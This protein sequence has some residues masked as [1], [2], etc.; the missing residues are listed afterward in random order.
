MKTSKLTG[1]ILI[2]LGI[3]ALASQGIIYANSG[4]QVNVSSLQMTSGPTEMVLPMSPLGGAVVLAGGI[5]LLI[6]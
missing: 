2:M 3:V 5:V 6:M 4:Q 1:L